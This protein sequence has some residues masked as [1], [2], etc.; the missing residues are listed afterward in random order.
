MF[1]KDSIE[2]FYKDLES[3]KLKNPNKA[4]HEATKY[5]KGTISIYLNKKDE[6]SENF[7]EKFYNKFGDSLKNGSVKHTEGQ[8]GDNS[9]KQGVGLDKE[10]KRLNEARIKMQA[11][12]DVLF[13]VAVELLSATSGENPTLIRK[14]LEKR[15]DELRK[16]SGD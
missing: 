14:K 10:E 15:V 6:P 11:T 3:L 7:L 1:T 4:I 13:D 2:Q 12:I 5:N 9:Q 8:Q 16:F